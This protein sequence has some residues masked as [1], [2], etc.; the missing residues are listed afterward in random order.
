MLELIERCF[1]ERWPAWRACV[2]ELVPSFGNKLHAD[3]DLCRDVRRRCT[4]RLG[5]E[6]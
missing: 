3:G 2:R 1:P 6:V 4:D 5:L